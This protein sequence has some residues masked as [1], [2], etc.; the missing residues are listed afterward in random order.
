MLLPDAL[1]GRN[2]LEVVKNTKSKDLVSF[3]DVDLVVKPPF[4]SCRSL[5]PY[6][7]YI[8]PVRFHANRARRY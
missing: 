6:H 5:G 3:G 8:F 2:G 1:L 4:L 7:H